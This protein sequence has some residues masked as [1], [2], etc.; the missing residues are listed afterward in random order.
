MIERFMKSKS[1]AER[2]ALI[3][4]MAEEQHCDTE[5]II[6]ILRSKGESAGVGTCK[7]CGKKY[8]LYLS[9]YCYSCETEILRRKLNGDTHKKCLQYAI[10]RCA[11]RK[12]AAQRQI[13]ELDLKILELKEELKAYG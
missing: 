11:A 2:Q 3:Y 4:K 7:L 9:E 6:E 12:L 10:E 1:A 8:P 13:V 5:T